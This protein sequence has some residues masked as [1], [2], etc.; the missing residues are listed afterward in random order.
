VPGRYLDGHGLSLNVAAPDRRHWSFRYQRQGRERVMSLGGA[1]VVTLAEARRLHTE[2]RAL[3]AKGIDPLDARKAAK[4]KPAHTF[5]EVAELYITTH[6]AAW[7]TRGEYHWRHSLFDYAAPAFGNKP[8]ADVGLDDVL[9]V[10]TPVWST[11]SGTAAVLR[12]RIELVLDFAKARGWRTAENPARWRGNLKML[13]PARAKL[14]AIEHRAALP[15]R[16][17]PVF[18]ANLMAQETGMKGRCLAFCVLT[19]TRSVE[20]RGATWAEIDFREKVWTVPASRMKGHRQHRVPLSEAAMEI[21]SALA[22]VRTDK[23]L[24]FLGKLPGRPLTNK[25]LCSL[26]PHLGHPGITVHGFRS[27]FRDWAADTGKPSDLAEAAL[28]HLPA[29]KVVQAYQRSDLLEARR[30]LMEAWA[31][32]LTRPAATLVPLQMQG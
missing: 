11:K 17:A 31:A 21:I 24:I 1:D 2:A 22:A 8:V 10:L 15:W 12:N 18:I 3:L 32:F 23:Q 13:L 16:L 28:A 7:R 27:C 29:S 5:S 20:A 30:G 25:T 6:R 26:L 9:A 14:H 19:T 4:H